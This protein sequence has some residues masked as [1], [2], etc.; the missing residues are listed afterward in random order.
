MSGFETATVIKCVLLSVV[1]FP[2]LKNTVTVRNLIFVS[3]SLSA[4]SSG[5]RAFLG[6]VPVLPR[7]R[8]DFENS[9]MGTDVT[10]TAHGE[11]DVFSG[12][13]SFRGSSYARTGCWG[14]P[15]RPEGR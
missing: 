13:L 8:D 9:A 14:R 6:G 7:P 11:P 15:A 2:G 5:K 12:G 3:T 1:L 10:R 4:F